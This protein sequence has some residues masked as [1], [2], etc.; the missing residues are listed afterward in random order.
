MIVL[1][2]IPQ[3]RFRTCFKISKHVT[4]YK[5]Q[6]SKTCTTKLKISVALKR[7]KQNI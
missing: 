1:H 4:N 6:K 5:Y 2:I 7:E 3:T